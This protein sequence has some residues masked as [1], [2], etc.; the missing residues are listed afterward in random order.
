LD[1]VPLAAL[2]ADPLPAA[3]ARFGSSLAPTTWAFYAPD[4]EYRDACAEK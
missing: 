1:L 3:C 4:V 2:E